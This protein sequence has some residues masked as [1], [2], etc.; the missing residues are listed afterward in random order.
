MQAEKKFVANC[1]LF[2]SIK[3]DSKSYKGKGERRVLKPNLDH[4]VP[5]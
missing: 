3:G 1:V 5:D 2:F 4:I